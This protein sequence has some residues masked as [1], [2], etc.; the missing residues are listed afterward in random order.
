MPR[1]AVFCPDK[2]LTDYLDTKR[3]AFPRFFFISDDELL[4]VLGSSDPASIQVH[5]LKLFAHHLRLTQWHTRPRADNVKDLAMSGGGCPSGCSKR[6]NLLVSRTP[7]SNGLFAS[8]C[9]VPKRSVV[10]GYVP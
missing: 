1:L 9:G 5:M 10:M 2:I 7:S 4:S 3:N 8:G 6:W